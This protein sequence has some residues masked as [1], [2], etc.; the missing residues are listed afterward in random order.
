MFNF[1]HKKDEDIRRDVRSELQWDPSVDSDDIQVNIKNGVVTLRGHVPYFYSKSNAEDAAR[2]VGGVKTVYDEMRVIPNETYSRTDSQIS[3]AVRI[4]LEWNYQIPASVIA[5][6]DDGLVKLSGQVDWD[7]Q[8]NA[9]NDAVA[10]LNGVCGVANEITI[11]PKALD[12]FAVKTQI[13]DALK[14]SAAIEGRNIVVE[15]DGSKV[16]LSG[17]MDSYDEIET[18]RVAAWNA[19]GVLDVVNQLTL[20]P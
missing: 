13:Q 14:R 3:E 10:S 7:Y 19:P 4:A 16:T 20:S 11:K 17:Q 2:R 12:S 15:V 9:A 5:T 18:A 8:R 1:F 6:V